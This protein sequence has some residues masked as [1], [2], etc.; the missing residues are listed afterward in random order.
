M[1]AATTATT[2]EEPADAAGAYRLTSQAG[3]LLRRA[4]QRHLAIF[5]ARMPELTPRQFAALAKLHDV[6][7]ETLSKADLGAP[8]L[9]ASKASE[10]CSSSEPW[11]RKL[12]CWHPQVLWG[13]A[14][15]P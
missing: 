7:A 4:N 3:H 15:M 14:A 6:S 2:G 9:L 12:C 13:S 10:P 5:A 8:A 11:M 1:T